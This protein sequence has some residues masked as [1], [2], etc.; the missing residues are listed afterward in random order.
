MAAY[1]LIEFTT[2]MILYTINSMLGDYQFIWIDVIVIAPLAF[3]SALLVSFFFFFFLIS[4]FFS[5]LICFN[6]RIDWT[7]QDPASGATH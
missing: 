3:F 2:E 5:F 4:L 7:R 6:S 1:S